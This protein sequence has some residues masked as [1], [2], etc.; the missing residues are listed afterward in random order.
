MSQKF[1][2][3]LFGF[4]KED[5]MSYIV[6]SKEKENRTSKELGELRRELSENRTE[7]E[8][9]RS[10][11]DETNRKLEAALKELS[12]FKAKEQEIDRLCDS[13]GKL[14]LVAQTNAA[15]IIESAKQNRD[16]SEKLVNSNL[17]AADEATRR[18]DEMGTNLKAKTEEFLRSIDEL[19]NL[20]AETKDTVTG[21]NEEIEKH[22]KE[23]ERLLAFAGTDK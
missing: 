3:S 20:A 22:S 12:E 13:I 4:N 17:S 21:N 5:V 10:D 9:V 16:E 8:S 14:Y 11:F 23:A 19:K 18:F 15:S 6:E 2:N 7:L 1:R